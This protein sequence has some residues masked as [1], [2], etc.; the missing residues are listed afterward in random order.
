MLI[1]TFAGTNEKEK[2]R[3][4]LLKCQSYKHTI[5]YIILVYTTYLDLY[6]LA[7]HPKDMLLV[8]T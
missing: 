1:S 5:F 4:S 3:Y 6:L 8:L 2:I 7:I